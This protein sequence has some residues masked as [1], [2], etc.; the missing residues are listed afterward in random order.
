M[1]ICF[2]LRYFEK[3]KGSTCAG[4]F[5]LKNLNK[6]F[7]L[8]SLDFVVVLTVLKKFNRKFLIIFSIVCHIFQ[9][10]QTLKHLSVKL[11]RLALPSLF[12]P[13]Q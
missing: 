4:S 10:D 2:G 7:Q 12:K 6:N 9:L 5:K 3:M 13:P 1:N 11:L 8:L